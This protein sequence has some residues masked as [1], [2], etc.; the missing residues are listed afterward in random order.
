MGEVVGVVVGLADLLEDDAPLDLDVPGAERRRQDDVAEQVERLGE[1]RVERA[2]VEAGVLLGRERVHVAAEPVDL[3]RDLRV[4]AAARP[5]EE[6]V[7]EKVREPPARRRLAADPART[8]KPSENERT[9]VIGS[10]RTVTP[11]SRT[12]WT[13]TGALRFRFLAAASAGFHLGMGGVCWSLSASPAMNRHSSVNS[14]PRHWKIAF[15]RIFVRT[16]TIGPTVLP[17]V[18][19]MDGGVGVSAAAPPPRKGGGVVV[20]WGPDG[21]LPEPGVLVVPGPLPP[22]GGGPEPIGAAS[23]V[24]AM[25]T[26]Q[27]SQLHIGSFQ[28]WRIVRGRIFASSLSSSGSRP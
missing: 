25:M 16:P 8:K 7:L 4:G 17:G 22:T 5:L 2:A 20:G 24:P 23:G 9:S 6:E 14:R 26:C 19:K 28:S 10:T 11:L 21:L 3:S 27:S 18:P 12:R 15:R 1:P 13:T